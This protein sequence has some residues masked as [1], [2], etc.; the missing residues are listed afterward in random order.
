MRFAS[1]LFSRRSVTELH[2]ESEKSGLRR[3]LGPLD[4]L[5]VYWRAAKIEDGETLQNLAREI[6]AGDAEMQ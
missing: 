5:D 4:L 2:A 3:T 6:I 1:R